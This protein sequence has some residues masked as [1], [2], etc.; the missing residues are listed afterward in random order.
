VSSETSASAAS[1]V[2]ER[3]ER[4]ARGEGHEVLVVQL[5][6]VRRVA[7]GEVGLQL[8]EVVVEGGR[9]VLDLDAGV[10]RLEIGDQALELVDVALVGR[11]RVVVHRGLG[12]RQT[13]DEEQGGQG[14]D[15]PHGIL[16]DANVGS[17]T[18][19]P[20]GVD[21]SGQSPL[22]DIALSVR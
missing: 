19:A 21:G 7:G 16:L 2:V 9:R 4:A 14:V 13:G 18:A 11:E 12:E 10:L 5:E 22:A 20:P 15:E 1:A 17:R 3:S 8:G 6:H